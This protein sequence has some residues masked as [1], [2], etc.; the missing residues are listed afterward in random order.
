MSHVTF[1]VEKKKI[2]FDLT[3]F[4]FK[5]IFILKKILKL[6]EVVD[7]IG[8]GTVINQTPPFMLIRLLGNIFIPKVFLVT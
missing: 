3:L 1:Y 8:G 7:Q 6:D 4:R 5:L 2:W